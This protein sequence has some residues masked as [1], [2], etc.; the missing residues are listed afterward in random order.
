MN[1]FHY[2]TFI[3][4][5]KGI[6][7]CDDILEIIGKKI[8]TIRNRQWWIDNYGYHLPSYKFKLNYHQ[9][10][11]KDIN[12]KH[13]ILIAKEYLRY[14]SLKGSDLIP[15][16]WPSIL[17]YTRYN[18]EDI[19]LDRTYHEFPSK[20]CIKSNPLLLKKTQNHLEF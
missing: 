9:I 15:K 8:E 13:T 16:F 18:W 7:L 10:R 4:N 2:K 14:Y 1:A 11:F 5:S 6:I 20:R 12:S 17:N 3:M 19:S